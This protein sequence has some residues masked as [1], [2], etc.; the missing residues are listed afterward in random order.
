MNVILFMVMSLNAKIADPDG[1]YAWASTEDWESFQTQYKKAGCII[2]G[3]NTYDKLKDKPTFPTDGCTCVV[4]SS[5]KKVISHHPK[6]IITRDSP[7]DILNMLKIKGFK[8]ILI[9]GGGEIN[10]LFMKEGLIDEVY[11][12]IEPIILGRGIPLFA[13]SDFKSRLQLLEVK[14]L[15]NNQTIQLHYKVLK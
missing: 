11:I 7:R 9:G 2:I 6:A 14:K 12:D 13:D 15:T 10:S 5:D 8:E 1:T 4:M 3:R